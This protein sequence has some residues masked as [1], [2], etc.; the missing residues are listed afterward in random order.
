MSVA[1][2]SMTAACLF[3]IALCGLLTH[4]GMIHRLLAVNIASSAVFLLLIA[5]GSSDSKGVDP[6]PQAMVL[7]GIVVSVSVTAFALAVTRHVHKLTGRS[8]LASTLDE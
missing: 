6:V 3:A 4:R 7:T 5:V 2:Y 8:T 1:I